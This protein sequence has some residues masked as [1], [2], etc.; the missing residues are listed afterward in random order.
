MSK[1]GRGL[2]I[3]EPQIGAHLASLNLFREADGSVRITVAGASDALLREFGD[4]DDLHDL[5]PIDYVNRLV[6]EAAEHLR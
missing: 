1:F 2:R 3:G 5:K 4:R 6:V